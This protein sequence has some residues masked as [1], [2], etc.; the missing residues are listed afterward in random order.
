MQMS[1]FYLPRFDKSG[2]EITADTLRKVNRILIV[3][4]ITQINSVKKSDFSSSSST[5]LVRPFTNSFHLNNEEERKSLCGS[6]NRN[7]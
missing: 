3:L 4:R 1:W 5:D 6:P 2:T 7:K